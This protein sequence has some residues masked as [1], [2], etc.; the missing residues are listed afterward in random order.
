MFRLALIVVLLPLAFA[1]TLAPT[2][3]PPHP[4]PDRCE[5]C[6][7]FVK[8]AETVSCDLVCAAIPPAER[9]LCKLI[10]SKPNCDKIVAWLEQGPFRAE[11]ICGRLGYCTKGCPCGRCT[12][13]TNGRCLSVRADR[14]DPKP[15]GETMEDPVV[16]EELNFNLFNRT[17]PLGKCGDA[18]SHQCCLHC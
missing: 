9:I 3:P 1:S 15:L 11:H 16:P 10:L 14:C 13:L 5:S 4:H 18:G 12:T 2:R 17:C 6:K 7:K 8:L